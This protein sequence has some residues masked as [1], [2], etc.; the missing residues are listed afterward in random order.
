MNNV[1]AT[2]GLSGISPR[3]RHI[4]FAHRIPANLFAEGVHEACIE[5]NEK[6]GL[7]VTLYDHKQ[8][9]VGS[10]SGVRHYLKVVVMEIKRMAGI[11][12]RSKNRIQTGSFCVI[13]CGN[14]VFFRVSC[15]PTTFGEG[16]IIE[17]GA[18]VA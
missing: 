6:Y 18:P 11:P 10:L 3:D 7:T 12:A 4:L 8:K 5:P 14:R 2:E 1:Q 9:N 13:I 16:I 15:Y 17:I